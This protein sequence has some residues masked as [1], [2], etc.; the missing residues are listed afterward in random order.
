MFTPRQNH[1]RS[2]ANAAFW[3]VEEW[4]NSSM[5]LLEIVHP[6]LAGGQPAHSI[7]SQEGEQSRTQKTAEQKKALRKNIGSKAKN[8]FIKP[9]GE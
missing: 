2:P 7:R 4:G 3:G 8:F 9:G 6:W 5:F 1:T